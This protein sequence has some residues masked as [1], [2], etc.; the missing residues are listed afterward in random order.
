VFTTRYGP[1]ALVTGAA[2]G[3]GAEFA[4]QLAPRAL[5][6]ILVDRDASAL[7]RLAASLDTETLRVVLDLAEPDCLERLRETLEDRIVGLLVSNAA[8]SHVGHFIERDLDLWLRQLEL[9]CRVPLTLAHELGGAMSRR[10]RGGIVLM[11]SQSAFQ[12]TA[13]VATYAA[14]KAF[15]RVLAEGLWLELGEHGVDVVAVAPGATDTPG[16][17]ATAPRP[18]VVGRRLQLTS[19]TVVAEAL[20]ALGRAPLVI[21][22]RG[23]RLLSTVLGLLPRRTRISLFAREMRRMYGQLPS[24]PS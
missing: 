11:S 18:T 9:G 21:P 2:R 8:E 24:G 4:R 19:A 12:G 23:N 16:L 17:R 22:G 1:W 7:D 6:L 13:Q 14:T 3:I 20:H 5:K 10:G 15:A